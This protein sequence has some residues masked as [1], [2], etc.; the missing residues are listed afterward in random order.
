MADDRALILDTPG[1]I[2]LARLDLLDAAAAVAGRLLVP[3]AVADEAMLLD[4]PGAAEV[5]GA[6]T[7]GRVQVLPPLDVR[8][9]D[10]GRG[11]AE[12]I[13]H[14]ETLSRPVLLDDLGA[15]RRATRRGVPVVGTMALLVRLAQ[16]GAVADIGEALG[17]LE[18]I[19]FRSTA[20][21][22]A[23]AERQGRA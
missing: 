6:I 11:E 3:A 15:R 4:R 14:A 10:L 19:G 16:T 2:A 8:D 1:L 20:A 21:L 17:A 13:A 23:R 12:A 22:R 5:R 7:G 18:A 9:H